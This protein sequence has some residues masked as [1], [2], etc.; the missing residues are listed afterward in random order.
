M[1]KIGAG[2]ILVFLFLLSV[3]L[4][5]AIGS[6]WLGARYM[7]LQGNFSGVAV[8]AAG[9]FL[10]YLY[11]ILVHR[12][13]L[14]LLPVREGNINPG[15][16]QEFAYQVYVLFYLIFFNSLLRSGI[17]PIPAMRVVYLL[18][19]ARLGKNTYSSGIILDPLFVSIGSNSIVGEAA[20]LVPHVIE[21]DTLGMY[22][23]VIGNH[24]TIGAHAVILSGVTIGDNVI[25]AANSL[26][27]K[28][29]RI[30]SGEVWVGSPARRLR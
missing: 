16:S 20:L 17:I 25:V 12:A 21:G 29:T 1:R 5:L 19:G 30:N 26:V 23:I 15:S 4:M 10:L 3:V 8:S 11:A 22:S 7:P 18:L 13:S 24:V 27:S 2:A 6:A 14:L 28:G 9:I